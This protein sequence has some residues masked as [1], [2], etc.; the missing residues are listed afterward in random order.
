V[1]KILPQRK[2][3]SRSAAG[4]MASDFRSRGADTTTIKAQAARALVGESQVAFSDFL[5]CF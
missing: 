3:K 5:Q 1:G 2:R 4:V